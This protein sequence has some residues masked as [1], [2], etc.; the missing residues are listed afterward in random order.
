[1]EHL[2]DYFAFPNVPIGLLLT[3][4]QALSCSHIFCSCFLRDPE[5]VSRFNLVSS[6]WKFPNP[7]SRHKR[8]QSLKPGVMDFL[9]MFQCKKFTFCFVLRYKYIIL[10]Y[11]LNSESLRRTKWSWKYEFFNLHYNENFSLWKY[12]SIYLKKL[13]LQ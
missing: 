3:N 4:A 6:C 10:Y 11:P 1:M 5:N 12:D 13:R 8:S 9:V 7:I 2:G